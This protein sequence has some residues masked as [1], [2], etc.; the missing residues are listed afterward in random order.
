MKDIP[1]RP[2]LKAPSPWLPST[3]DRTT[4]PSTYFVSSVSI[5]PAPPRP[6]DTSTAMRSRSLRTYGMIDCNQ[7]FLQYAQ[8]NAISCIALFVMEVGYPFVSTHWSLEAQWRCQSLYHKPRLTCRA[9]RQKSRG[10]QGAGCATWL[11]VAE[12]QATD[13]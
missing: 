1:P 2:E 6:W 8:L 12:T 7:K 5:L 13:D 10:S 4:S 3:P 9:I 11:L